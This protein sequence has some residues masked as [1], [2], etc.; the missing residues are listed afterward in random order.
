MKIL[1]SS[2]ITLDL[3]DYNL[4]IN[5]AIRKDDCRSSRVL[6]QIALGP[7]QLNENLLEWDIFLFV[8]I[9]S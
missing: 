6:S 9:F 2:C 4:H 3:M 1:V 5:G 8:C 7:H